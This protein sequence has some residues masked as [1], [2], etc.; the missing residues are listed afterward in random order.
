MVS[1]VSHGRSEAGGERTSATK[2]NVLPKY[3]S[4]EFIK[5]CIIC[6]IIFVSLYLMIDFVQKIDNFIDANASKDII[7]GYFLLKTPFIITQMIPVATLISVIILF[8]VMKRNNEI[9][10]LKACGIDILRLSQTVIILALFVSILSFLFSEFFVPYTSTRSNEIWD[11]EVEKQDPNRFYGSDQIWYRSD[12][13]IYWIKHFDFE[14]KIMQKPTFYFFDEGFRLI[15]RI[16]G[17]RGVWVNSVWKI[18]KVLVHELQK[19]GGYELTKYNDLFL[20]IPE[21][22]DTFVRK[23]K[24]PEEMSFL[25]LKRY[26][27]RVQ[28]EGYDNTRYRVDMDTKLALPFICLA[29]A[30]FGIPIALDLKVGGI[31]L[32]ISLGVGLSFLYMVIMSFSRYLGLSGILPPVLSAW[33]ANAGF[34]LFGVYLILNMER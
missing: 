13:S 11:I 20:E 15:K 7:I 30:L 16:E 8:S 18:E 31:P 25:Q 27:E 6:M 12:H 32:A 21:T 19:D 10:A 3:I 29:L 34:M 14:K 17:D 24:K 33:I 26:S 9:M 1:S 5:L 2:M 23:I 22:P 28:R 4:K